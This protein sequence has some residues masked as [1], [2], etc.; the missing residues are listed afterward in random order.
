MKNS[1]KFKLSQ[2]L[3]EFFRKAHEETLTFHEKE[4]TLDHIVAQIVITYLDGEGNIP[5]LA[6]YISGLFRTNGS[7][8]GFRETVIDVI[9]ELRKTNKFTA[10]GK[11]YTGDS[12]IVLSPAVNHILRKIDTLNGGMVKEIDSLAFFMCSLPETGY[13]EIVKHLLNY[14][15]NTRE[16]VKIYW[17]INNFEEK[18]DKIEE[19][20]KDYN[21]GELKEK[22]IEFSDSDGSD[23]DLDPDKKREEDDREFEMAGQGNSEPENV[24]PNSRTPFLD[25]FST[26]MTLSARNGEY[27]PI[28]GRDKEI[29]QIIEILSCRKKNNGI[30]LA[31]AGC[32][33][34]AIIEGLCQKIVNK[35]VPKELIDKRIFSLDLNA[36]VAGCQFR[37]QYEE[38]LDAIIKEVENNPEII[39]YID[40]IHNLVGNGSNDGKGDGANILKG[41]LARGKFR[42]LGSTTTS[43]Y[44]KYIEKDS[45]LKR[46]F[47]IVT[48]SEPNRE[49]TLDIL[50]TLKGR[51]EEYHRV[52]YTDDILKLCVELSGRYIYDRHFPDK[53]ID[54]IDI[55]ASAAKLRKNIDTSSV[56][57]LEKA[58]DDIIKE[59]IALVEKQDF[60]EAQKRRDTEMVLREELEK[61]RTKLI[62]ELNDPS[63][64][65]EVTEEDVMTVV[66]KISNVP[67][68]KMKDSEA[69]K[70]RNMKKVLE[71]EVIGQQD[72]V[73]TIVTALQKSI[74]DIQDPNK[75]ICTAFLL[76]PTG[77]GKSL[78]SKKIAELFFES[79][80]KNLL[81][82]NMGEYTE[83][84]SI[85]RLLGSAPGYIGSD[86]DTAVFEKIRTNPNMVVVFDEIEKAHKDIYDL[87]LGIL[88]TGKANLSN[89]LEVNFKN[90]VILLTSNVASKQLSEKGNGLGFSK[91]SQD[92][93]NKDNKSIVMKAMEKFFRPEFIGRLSNIVIF[94]EL[95]KPEMMKIFDLELTKLSDR[96]SKKGYKLSVS[97]KLKEF[98]IDQVNTKYGARDLSKN[99]SKY[100][101]DKL[102]LAMV[103][104]E[105]SG[106]IINLDLGDNSE[107]IISDSVIME[108]NI[109]KDKVNK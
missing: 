63:S 42:C 76:G 45:A 47:Q 68:N 82:I 53:A 98:I 87:L 46:R 78:I 52:K 58:I 92:E 48:V 41:P 66:S 91:Q 72:A 62:G 8:S 104:G 12:H 6:E 4:V 61:E 79:V 50:K 77:V 81:L 103:N 32:G 17:D 69:I 33:K 97:E 3:S 71:K 86:S 18:T 28:V 109:E 88:D 10:P 15:A 64:W 74:L 40:E 54:C 57:N 44:K 90:C 80:E 106:N 85:S 31:E 75:P 11:L 89:G 29:S 84:Y 51:Y 99:I 9:S 107:V 83:S 20:I 5:E 38:R 105:I 65:P 93:R 102:A 55:A 49:E 2:E 67:I 23:L 7:E 19:N 70:I 16:L 96:L 35:E 95:G 59:K 108:L 26:D 1:S 34:T 30:L 43:E 14:G 36:L 94:N 24:D 73:D 21:S 60:D 37:G 39:I 13:S 100:V 27:D 25:K 56:D 22:T 101:E